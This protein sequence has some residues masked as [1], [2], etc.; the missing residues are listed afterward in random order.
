VRSEALN[1]TCSNLD[2]A[3]ARRR[4]E[5][6]HYEKASTLRETADLRFPGSCGLKVNRHVACDLAGIPELW[7]VQL[8]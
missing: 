5:R 4:P 3:L 1:S 8:G 2:S 6:E 7:C